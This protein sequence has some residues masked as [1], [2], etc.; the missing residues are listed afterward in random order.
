MPEKISLVKVTTG[1]YHVEIK[2]KNLR[3]LCGCPANVIK[4]LKKKKLIQKVKSDHE[5]FKSYDIGPNAILLSDILIQNGSFSNMSEFPVLHM[6][7]I[8]GMMIPN[9]PNNKGKKPIIIGT[10]KQLLSQQ[11]YIKRGNYGLINQSEL[12]D[13]DI[14]Y[15]VADELMK[16]KLH[17]AFGNIRDTKELI[18]GI[19]FRGRIAK[20]KEDVLV[21]RKSLNVFEISY[22]DEK[23]IVN[24]NLKVDE[25]YEA[26]YNLPQKMIERSYFSIINTGNGNGWNINRPTTGSMISFQ[27]RLFLIDSGPNISY[28]LA[29]L[30]VD[31]GELEGIFITHNHDDHF[32]GLTTL[33]TANHKIKLFAPKDVIM[34]IYRK[35]TALTHVK[36]NEFFDYFHVR[37]L[38]YGEWQNV[39]GLEVFAFRSPH[40]V[41]TAIYRFRAISNEGDTKIYAH[42]A[43]II[44]NR[45]LKEMIKSFNNGGKTG[46]S[47]KN[48]NKVMEY[49]TE[50]ADLKKI[51]SDG[52]LIHGDALDFSEVDDDSA[53]KIISHIDRELTESEKQIGNIT[54]FGDEIIMIKSE[55]DYYR[56]LAHNYLNILFPNIPD[57]EL[58]ILLNCKIKKFDKSELFIKIGDVDSD[59]FLLITGTISIIRPNVLNTIIRAGSIV[60][61]V[62]A[63]E[64]TKRSSTCKT[65]TPCRMLIIPSKVLKHFL[66]R[67]NI[68]EKFIKRNK[69]RLFFIQRTNVLDNGVSSLDQHT[70]AESIIFE[71]YEKG[72]IIVQEGDNAKG[73]IIIKEGEVDIYKE[74]L[75]FDTLRPYEIACEKSF[76][77]NS[78]SIITVIARTKCLIGRTEKRSILDMP[79]IR[80]RLRELQAKRK[81]KFLFKKGFVS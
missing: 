47:E 65:I 77:E 70:I 15:G 79:I 1:V 39:D 76:L 48:A 60:G 68:K 6:L 54:E 59:A 55:K 38:E 61:E 13:A 32:A 24:L 31:V 62:A 66:Q 18:E 53:K 20:I 80:F 44:S 74:G 58:E 34:S 35:F 7:Y 49:Y 37:Y 28:I 63:L 69:D 51:D 5:I 73:L 30:G 81:E 64:D 21:L 67:N 3:I 78:K 75:L 23:V 36:Q 26:P 71:K 11:E 52:G 12:L 16:I 9:H 41:E 22:N 4:H 14:L 57:H 2:E 33:M 43:D 72:D 56:E 27:G 25:Q 10:Q 40:P 46:I 42:N 17:F 19:P 8:Q 45:V 29:S 50:Y